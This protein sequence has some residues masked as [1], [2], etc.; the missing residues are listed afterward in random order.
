[1]P[2]D[3]R[4]RSWAMRRVSPPGL[5]ELCRAELTGVCRCP[6]R[7]GF[8]DLRFD[9]DGTPWSWCFPAAGEPGSRLAGPGAG[10]L[11]LRPGPHGLIAEVVTGEAGGGS[12]P[13]RL[14]L[15]LAADL[16][17][18][19]TPVFVHRCLIGRASGDGA[20]PVRPPAAIGGGQRHKGVR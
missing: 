14:D 13:V 16:A 1:M 15:A 5:P 2:S 4:Y 11:V 10:S 12:R 19:A 6:A 18:A 8:R 20:R 7:E 17:A 3:E 9:V